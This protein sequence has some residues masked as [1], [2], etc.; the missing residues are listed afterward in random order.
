MNITWL[1]TASL[2]LEAAGER[3]LFDPFLELRGGE[4]PGA[5]EDFLR[6]DVIFI[7]HGH[8]DH[9]Y[10]LPQILEEGEA[11]VFCTSAPART[12]EKYTEETGNVV[13]LRIGQTVPIGEIRIRA[14]QGRHIEFDKR[15]VK[16]ILDPR[17]LFR[18]WRN[19][20]FLFWANRAFQERGETVAFHIQA[21]GKEI[22]LFGSLNLDPDTVYP[23]NVDLLILPYQGSCELE[24]EAE[25]FIERLSPKRI[26]LTHFDNAFP[27]LSRNVDTRPLKRLIREK[28]PEIQV[29]KPTFGK[30]ITLH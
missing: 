18:G 5:L 15:L 16:Y 3:I 27:P 11:T 20:P 13:E 25:H 26:L 12:L 1:G 24:R 23:R 9:L 30:P 19:L 28:Y 8:F 17:R 2:L 29:V 7:T 6:E 21:E 10:F 14:L 22:L 4:H